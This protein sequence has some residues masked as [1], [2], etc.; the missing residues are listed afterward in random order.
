MMYTF[1][2]KSDMTF[3]SSGK[4]TNLHV[5]VEMDV[6]L[7]QAQRN[8]RTSDFDSSSPR[9]HTFFLLH[10]SYEMSQTNFVTFST[11]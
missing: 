1:Q 2:K 7:S 5:T 6:C 4:Y 10:I 8:T 9:I 11:L 3:P